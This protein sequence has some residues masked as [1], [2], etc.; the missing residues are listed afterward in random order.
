MVEV[1]G[2]WRRLYNEFL[3]DVSLSP[4]IIQVINSRSR[5][6]WGM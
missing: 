3:H 5:G 1:T 4:Y 2:E 6:V